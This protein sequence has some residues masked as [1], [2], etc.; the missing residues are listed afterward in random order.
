[1]AREPTIDLEDG[2]E[3]IRGSHLNKGQKA[4]R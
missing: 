1:M 3:P 2:G 4:F